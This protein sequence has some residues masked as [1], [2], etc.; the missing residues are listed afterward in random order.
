MKDKQVYRRASVLKKYRI[1]RPGVVPI[2]YI[3]GGGGNLILKVTH[4]FLPFMFVQSSWQFEYTVRPR[5]LVHF[6][7]NKFIIHIRLCF[8]DDIIAATGRPP[9]VT[10]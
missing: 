2:S 3:G 10:V 5:G 6:F 9:N 1:V 8:L 7:Y 4:L